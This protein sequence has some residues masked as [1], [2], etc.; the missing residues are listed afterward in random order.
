MNLC[1]SK[2]DL[3]SSVRVEYLTL[4]PDFHQDDNSNTKFRNSKFR[5]AGGNITNIIFYETHICTCL[6]WVNWAGPLW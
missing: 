1:H 5:K 2:L 4:D 3:E 6:A